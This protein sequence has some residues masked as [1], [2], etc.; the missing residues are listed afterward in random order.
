LP[1]CA[2]SAGSEVCSIAEPPIKSRVTDGAAR[3]V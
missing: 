2:S 1:M 3:R